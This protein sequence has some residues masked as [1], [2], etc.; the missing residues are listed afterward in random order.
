MASHS[1]DLG[2]VLCAPPHL[3]A[4][5]LGGPL[6]SHR[7]EIRI[8]RHLSPQSLPKV[9]LEPGSDQF[10]PGVNTCLVSIYCIPSYEVIGGG[11]ALGKIRRIPALGEHEF[12][13][14]IETQVVKSVLY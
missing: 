3:T 11:M 14:E 1:L 6:L 5:G 12:Q 13:G 10:P 2:R 4:L 8:Q 9:P 7:V